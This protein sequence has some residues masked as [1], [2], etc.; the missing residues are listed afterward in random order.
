MIYVLFK[1]IFGDFSTFKICSYL[2]GDSKLDIKYDER[3]T[4]KGA[5]IALKHQF[6]YQIRL[7]NTIIYYFIIIINF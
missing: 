7:G 6:P 5:G 4:A 2:L 1:V 3:Q